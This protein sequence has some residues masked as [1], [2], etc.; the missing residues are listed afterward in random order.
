MALTSLG[1]TL[2]RLVPSPAVPAAN[3]APARPSTP[4]APAA[5]G[6]RLTLSARA[7]EDPAA[8]ERLAARLITSYDRLSWMMAPLDKLRVLG[9]IAATRTDA[10]ADTVQQAYRSGLSSLTPMQQE[11]LIGRFRTLVE[12]PTTPGLT[13]LAE[14]RRQELIAFLA[15]EYARFGQPLH[16]RNALGAALATSQSDAASDVLIAEY[17]AA[18]ADRRLRVL[19]LMSVCA[20]EKVATFL[21]GE[22]DRSSNADEKR[23]LMLT[24]QE[25]LANPLR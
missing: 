13:P 19:T 12:L 16:V 4:A 20:T 2:A 22:F 17:K 21:A 11:A 25:L 18:P 6:D 1:Q 8:R 10:A 15:S 9:A 5:A 3:A 14:P 7:G 24:L 23:D